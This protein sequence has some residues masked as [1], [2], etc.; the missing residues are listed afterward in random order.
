MEYVGEA[1]GI[2]EPRASIPTPSIRRQGARKASGAVWFIGPF[3][4]VYTAFFVVPLI[5]LFRLSLTRTRLGN[6]AGPFVGGGNYV[7]LLHDP[8]FWGAFVHT[9]Y[10]VA[11]TVVPLVLLGL[12][13]AMLVLRAGKLTLFAQAAFFLPYILPVSVVTLIAAWVLNANYGVVNHLLGVSIA[14]FDDATLGLPAVAVVTVW[15]TVG[16]NMLLFLAGLQTVPKEVK[17][18][19]WLDGAGSWQVF[20]HVIWPLL[21]PTTSLALTLQV[22]ASLKIFSQ[23]YLLTAGGPGTSTRVLLEYMF[24]TGFSNLDSSYASAIAVA[25]FLEIV[26]ISAVQSRL[27]VGYGRR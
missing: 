7:R 25:I 3:A 15:W 10:F 5:Q 8:A 23:V 19:A 18:A 22:I 6:P 27:L 24:D 16:F 11:L 21:W 1:R 20:R 26:V 12:I 4:T 2:A 17:E 9:L 13:L 14:W